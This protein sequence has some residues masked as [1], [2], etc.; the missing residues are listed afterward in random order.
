MVTVMLLG[1]SP[2][3]SPGYISSTTALPSSPIA[4]FHLPLTS[5]LSQPGCPGCGSPWEE[6]VGI[7]SV[8]TIIALTSL[9]AAHSPGAPNIGGGPSTLPAGSGPDTLPAGS[10]PNNVPAGSGPS[11]VP[12]GN[13][14]TTTPTPTNHGPYLTGGSDKSLKIHGQSV[15]L[16]FVVAVVL[17]A[18]L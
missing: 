10:G 9:P 4:P 2:S 7:E 16:G 14:V 18:V 15:V 17:M 1:G 8:T 6:T 12:V 5:G 3:G 11:T 13:S